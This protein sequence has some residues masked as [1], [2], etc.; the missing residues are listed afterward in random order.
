MNSVLKDSCTFFIVRWVYFFSSCPSSVCFWLIDT[1][2]SQRLCSLS[3]FK[4]SSLS[5]CFVLQETRSGCQVRSCPPPPG[6]WSENLSA[7]ASPSA[8]K[9]QTWQTRTRVRFWH[10]PP[11]KKTRIRVA[12]A[13]HKRHLADERAAQIGLDVVVAWAA[14]PHRMEGKLRPEHFL[15]R[16]FCL[17]IN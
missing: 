17:V 16:Q 11:Q 9:V 12:V 3:P 14:E 15:C 1:F 5:P 6:T 13:D 2:Y 7:S 8:S 4:N 10:P